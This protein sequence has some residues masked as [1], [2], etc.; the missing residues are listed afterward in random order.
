MDTRKGGHRYCPNCKRV[1]ETTVL[2]EGYRQTE[3]LGTLAKKRQVICGTDAEGSGGC[4]T[5]WFTL[6]IPEDLVPGAAG[7]RGS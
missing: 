4:G 6:E 1:V 2:L 3:V 7:K 5:K